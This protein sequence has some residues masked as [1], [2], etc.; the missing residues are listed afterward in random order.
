MSL[1]DKLDFH[2]VRRKEG[3]EE[4]KERRR[5]KGWEGGK[6]GVQRSL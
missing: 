3:G 1:V 6:E 2:R 4:G 5:E